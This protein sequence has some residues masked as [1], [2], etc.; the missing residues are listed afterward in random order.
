MA[1]VYKTRPIM[2]LV[3]FRADFLFGQ[4]TADVAM[5]S[6]EGIVLY[7]CLP[8]RIARPSFHTYAPLFPVL[9]TPNEIIA[10]TLHFVSWLGIHRLY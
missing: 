7:F 1:A 5:S 10:H 3:G 6:V 9:T 2:P 8:P 4:A